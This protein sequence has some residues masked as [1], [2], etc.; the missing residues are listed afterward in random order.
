[1]S[2]ERIEDWNKILGPS[3]Q[4]QTKSNQYFDKLDPE[5]AKKEA[6]EGINWHGNVLRLVGRWI[7][8]GQSDNE[9]HAL[10]SELTL[11]EYSHTDTRKEVQ[12]MI[13]GGRNKGFGLDRFGTNQLKVVPINQEQTSQEFSNNS[14]YRVKN[15]QFYF[16]NCTKPKQPPNRLSNFKAEITHE[17]TKVDGRDNSK[18][19]LVEGHLFNGIHLPSIEIEAANFD[20]L[21]WLTTN[22]GSK[23]QITVGTRHKDHIVAAIKHISKPKEKVIY[24]YTGWV[25]EADKYTYLSAAG[26]ISSKGY[27]DQIET[28]LQDILASYHLPRS[29]INGPVDLSPILIDF[30]KIIDDGIGLLLIGGVFRSVLS[31]FEPCPVSIFLQG[32]TGTYKSAIA[33]CIQAFF[34]KKFNG[35]H[36][37]E[38]WSSTSNAIEKKAFLAKD[39]LFTIDDFVARGTASDVAAANSKAERVFRAQGNQSGR[40]RLTTTTEIRGAYVPRGL[41]LATGE[42]IPN[43]HSLQARLVIISIDKGATDIPTLTRLQEAADQG[44]LSQIMSEFIRW[45]A[46][47]ADNKK[48]KVLLSDVQT[49]CKDLIANGGHARMKD[50]LS[51]LL[52]G[53]WLFLEFGRECNNLPDIRIQQL[54]ISAFNTVK[55]LSQQQAIVNQ[56]GS[57]AERFIELL[58]DVLTMGKAHLST[59][60]GSV[61]FYPNLLGWKKTINGDY[62]KVESQGSHIGWVDNGSIYLNPQPALSVIKTLS[63]QVG[64]HLGSSVKTIGKALKEAGKLQNYNK[65]EVTRKVTI[66]GSRQCI[67]D[68]PLTL[69]VEED[70]TYESPF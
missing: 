66:L 70:E 39:T 37:P 11:P 46:E 58:Q 32:T 50:N 28:E 31:E 3:K 9:I 1:M 40:G 2:L 14:T 35:S 63:N 59:K 64:D 36:L 15:N 30:E 45:V 51:N 61:P 65:G 56:E 18:T 17:I 33:G 25:C 55:K 6:L 29:S 5:V 16:I 69:I 67:F 4:T 38:N 48:I 54:K 20:K 60:D 23:A 8:E 43:G 10:A 12:K 27:N 57:I 13:D 42:D 34:G 62:E 53:L 21:D 44:L 49:E 22:W 19:F 47:K 52:S 7:S 41:I 68:L 24:K 26:S